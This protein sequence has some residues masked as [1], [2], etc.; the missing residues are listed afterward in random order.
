MFISFKAII[1]PDTG[2]KI[3]MPFRMSGKQ[4]IYGIQITVLKY[5]VNHASFG[6]IE[7]GLSQYLS[8]KFFS[9]LS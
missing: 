6:F 8:A 3:F 2:E 5:F 4:A 1:H 9:S 7:R